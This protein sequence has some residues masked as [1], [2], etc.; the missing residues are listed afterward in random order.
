MLDGHI[1]SLWNLYGA[2]DGHPISYMVMT[3]RSCDENDMSLHV[4]LEG[5]LRRKESHG[6]QKVVSWMM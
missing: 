4:H 6:L 1:E 2:P 5:Y 3:L